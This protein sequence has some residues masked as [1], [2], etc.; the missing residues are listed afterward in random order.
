[1]TLVVDASVVVAAL[2]DKTYV[3]SWAEQM[4]G[5]EPLA[6]PEHMPVEAA[7]VLRRATLA[8]GVSIPF[9]QSRPRIGA[10]VA[11]RPASQSRLERWGSESARAVSRPQLAKAAARFV[12]I[13]VLPHPPFGL[14]MRTDFTA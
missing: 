11:G 12:A 7:N 13:V 10:A 2:T 8:G 14:A 6:A 4:M 9:D 5:S 1:M 3:G